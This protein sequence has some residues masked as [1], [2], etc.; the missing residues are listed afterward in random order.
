MMMLRAFATFLAIA[1]VPAPAAAEQITIMSWN[2]E[3]LWDG[4]APE[5]GKANFAWKG[6]E[7]AA[8]ERITHVANVIAD[9]DPDIVVLL[10]I[11]NGDVLSRL[12]KRLPAS[13][14]HPYF[15]QGKDTF[16]GQDIGI[17]SRHQPI[18]IGRFNNRAATGEGARTV[19]V[20]KNIVT[21]FRISRTPVALVAVHLRSGATDPAR[22]VIRQ[23]QATALS[24]ALEG[25]S[26]DGWP[27]IVLG[28][29]NDFDDTP[30]DAGKNAPRTQVLATVK[31]S[32]SRDLRNAMA[33]MRP[34]E[35]WTTWFDRNGNR[36]P[37]HADRFSAIDHIL[38]DPVFAGRIVSAGIIHSA[39]TSV[40]DHEPVFVR[41]DLP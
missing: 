5:E 21:G 30:Q 13:G 19:G 28:D 17:L 1:I 34:G 11:E 10:E 37:D 4:Q 25:L 2:T 15:V 35:R 39:E 40:S 24:E 7:T 32:G 6:D 14:Y 22:G 9:A 41:L 20:S 31:R 23:A 36:R 16:T 29:F 3:F 26:N 12:S 33:W 18:S 27:L 8:L 38:L